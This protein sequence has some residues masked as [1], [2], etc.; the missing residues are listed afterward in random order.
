MQ[1]LALVRKP[2]GV[3][4]SLGSRPHPATDSSDRESVTHSWGPGVLID[5]EMARKRD[6]GRD[7]SSAC[8]FFSFLK[9]Y[10]F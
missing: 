3:R 7:S 10:I 6:S 9:F 2:A 1:R 5:E 4:R 8:L